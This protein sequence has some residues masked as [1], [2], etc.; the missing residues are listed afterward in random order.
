MLRKKIRKEWGELKYNLEKLQSRNQG[1][2]RI[3]RLTKDHVT[4]GN[5]KRK[6]FKA[7]INSLILNLKGVEKDKFRI[8]V[9]SLHT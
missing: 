4:V 8:R 3:S 2:T 6:N 5:E 1:N 7:A 9:L